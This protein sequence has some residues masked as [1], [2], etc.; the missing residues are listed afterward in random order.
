MKKTTRRTASR[1]ATSAQ[2]VPDDR[3]GSSS[4]VGALLTTDDAARR[5]SISNRMLRKLVSEGEIPKVRIGSLVR[6]D[7][8]D[9][10]TWIAQ[11]KVRG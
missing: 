7:E 8:A 6:F 5:L 2:T 1:S 11:M 10:A 3:S 9:I 4:P